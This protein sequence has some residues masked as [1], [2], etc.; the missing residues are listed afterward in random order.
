MCVCVCVCVCVSA[1]GCIWRSEDRDLQ[2]SVV[3]FYHVGSADST[4]VDTLGGKAIIDEASYP[5]CF[6]FLLFFP[7]KHTMQ[8]RLNWD[9]GSPASNSQGHCCLQSVACEMPYQLRQDP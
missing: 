2:E 9:L 7:T 1:T 8:M 3:S 5:P 6:S 4:Q